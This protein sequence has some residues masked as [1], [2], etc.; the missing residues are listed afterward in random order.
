MSV[1]SWGSGFEKNGSS[2]TS[3]FRKNGSSANSGP[4]KN[5]SFQTSGPE[6][7][8]CPRKFDFKPTVPPFRLE[9][10]SLSCTV[11]GIL[12]RGAMPF[13]VAPLRD[14]IRIFIITGKE[15]VY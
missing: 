7:N 4:E 5:G 8:G 10:R 3:G 6:K 12:G 15:W 14:Y 11:D 1:L 2:G 9:L 13:G